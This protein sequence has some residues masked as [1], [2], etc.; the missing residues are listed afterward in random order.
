MTS[1]QYLSIF[2]FGT[3]MWTLIEYSI[4]R[5]VF[6]YKPGKA[7]IWKQF[8]F[9][10]HGLHH[11]VRFNQPK[12]HHVCSDDCKYFFQVPFDELRLVFPPI[13]ALFLMSILYY[14]VTQF[15]SNSDIL[16]LG[17]VT[18]DI[19]CITDSI[20]IIFLLLKSIYRLFNIRYDPLFHPQFIAERW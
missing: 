12:N 9:L 1:S 19:E 16:V 18:G 4:H 14:L 17:I 3:F 11:K 13:P 15:Y 8:H 20:S 2:I 7:V 10:I 6:H 5:W